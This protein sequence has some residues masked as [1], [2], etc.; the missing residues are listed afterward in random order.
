MFESP[1][2]CDHLTGELTFLTSSAIFLIGPFSAQS[3]VQ[4]FAS[5]QCHVLF[6]PL[7]HFGRIIQ[8]EFCICRFRLHLNTVQTDMLPWCFQQDVSEGTTR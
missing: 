6:E 7:Q 5:Q 1:A 4:S 2:E 3:D 8:L